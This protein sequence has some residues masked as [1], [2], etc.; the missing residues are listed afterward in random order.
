MP[1]R[2]IAQLSSTIY[3]T[4]DVGDYEECPVGYC[5]ME[6]CCV[7]STSLFP[8]TISDTHEAADT[9]LSSQDGAKVAGARPEE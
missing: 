3:A 6:R 7:C 5:V 8:H 2:L 1:L 9:G 4:C